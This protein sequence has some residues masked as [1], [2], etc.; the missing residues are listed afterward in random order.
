MFALAFRNGKVDTGFFSKA[1]M[2]K[3][4]GPYSHVEMVFAGPLENAEC[5][6]SRQPHG[7]GWAHIDLSDKKA[8]DI[9]VLTTTPEQEQRIHAFCDGCGNKD[10]D[11]MG[12]LGFVLPWGEHD[13]EDRFCS[14]IATEALQKVLGWWQ[15]VKPWKI[16]P[17]ALYQLAT[18]K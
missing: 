2:W 14:E 17:T 10:Y 12:I 16:S 9:V 8:W 3:T 4:G 15:D 13:D 18:S 5:F 6:S 1:I 11:W 7:T